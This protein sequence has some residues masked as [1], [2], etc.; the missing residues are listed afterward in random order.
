MANEDNTRQLSHGNSEVLSA[1][2]DLNGRL[3]T[4]EEIIL[5]RLNDTRPFEHQIMVRINELAASQTTILE[6]IAGIR[7]EQTAMRADLSDFRQETNQNFKVSNKKMAL[8][9]EEFLNFRAEQALL[10]KRVEVLEER[11][12]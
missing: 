2:R 11:A 10:E 4:V 1:I 5:A 9:S 7:E 6:V 8:L 12:A 3:T